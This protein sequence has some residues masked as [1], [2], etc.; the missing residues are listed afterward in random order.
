M[1]LEKI[2]DA[3]FW[4][5]AWNR[6]KESRRQ[7]KGVKSDEGSPW[8]RRAD[9][10][11]RKAGGVEGGKRTQAVLNFLESEGVLTSQL[12]V[13]DVGCG[14]GTITLP[15]A[16]RVGRVYALDPSEKMLKILQENAAAEG[17]NNVEVFQERWQDIDLAPKGWSEKF[18]LAFA[19]M[20]PG[21][22]S[23]EDLGKLIESSKRYGYLSTFAGRKDRAR[24]EIMLEVV[25]ESWQAGGMDVIYPLNLLYAWGYRPSLRFFRHHRFER[26]EPEKAEEE[27]LQYLQMAVDVDAKVRDKVRFYVASRLVEGRF[28]Y[29]REYFQ[30]MLLWDKKKR[31]AA[32]GD[33]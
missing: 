16:K 8:D 21:V 25:G 14:P 17:V 4:E 6:A 32:T 7:R 10:F 11:A 23:A 22:S 28:P 19:S 2:L 18:D 9:H 31:F 1:E 15:L 5:E 20:S 30:G 24:D 26:L 12:T 33:S 3:S 13:I 29:E 27:L